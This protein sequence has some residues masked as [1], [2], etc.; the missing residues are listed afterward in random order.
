MVFF[1]YRIDHAG[2]T[3]VTSTVSESIV[4]ET[5]QVTIETTHT[6]ETTTVTAGGGNSV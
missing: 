2:D 3:S 4:T 6:T 1:H 5:S